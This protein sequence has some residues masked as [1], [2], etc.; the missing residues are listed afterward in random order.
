M[1]TAV[2]TNLREKAAERKRR[3][4]IMKAE[5]DEMEAR[6]KLL[7]CQA[8]AKQVKA[9]QEVARKAEKKEKKDKKR[10]EEKEKDRAK[11]K[12]HR[13]KDTDK[14]KNKPK[15]KTKTKHAVDAIVIDSD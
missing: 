13:D 14:N 10:A 7:V 3:V 12:K 4:A 6:A 1:S 8:K 5:I 11:T 9:A 15:K 2:V